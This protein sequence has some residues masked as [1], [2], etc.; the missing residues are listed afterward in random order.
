MLLLRRGL[1]ATR[2]LSAATPQ[3]QQLVSRRAPVL[4][5]FC[6]TQ[7][8]NSESEPPPVIFPLRHIA[9]DMP[10]AMRKAFGPDNM[11]ASELAKLSLHQTIREW[12]RHQRDTGS[13]AVQVAVYTKKIERL[14]AHMQRNHKDKTTKRRLIM[15]VLKRNRM[16]KYMRREDREAYTSVIEGFKIRPTRNF[17]PTISSHAHPSTT[18]WAAKGSGKYKPKRRK[19]RAKPYGLEGTAKGRAKLRRH[20]T[21]QRRLQRKRDA[22]VEEER[23]VQAVA[24]RQAQSDASEASQAQRLADRAAAAKQTDSDPA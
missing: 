19:S 9:D 8:G 21:Y 2:A 17:D 1:G 16:L 15:L 5:R 20:A 23:R 12:Q 13:P 14:S 10:D 18:S 22:V 7:S 4:L 3:L 24:K 11:S 6:S